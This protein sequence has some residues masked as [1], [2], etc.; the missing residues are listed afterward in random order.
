MHINLSNNFDY[1]TA[2]EWIDSTFSDLSEE[3]LN[4]F[5]DENIP[6]ID[7]VG[8][9]IALQ[10]A[11]ITIRGTGGICQSNPDYLVELLN[12]K[13]IEFGKAFPEFAEIN[14]NYFF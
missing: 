8:Q 10:I 9:I 3:E 12:Q 4:Q 5:W 14:P 6:L 7:T 13:Q 2:C 11:I 1:T